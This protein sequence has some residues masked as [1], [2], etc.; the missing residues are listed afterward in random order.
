M[1]DF[2]FLIGEWNVANRRQDKW[3]VGSQT[4]EEF[5]AHVVGR[6]HFD[7]AASFDEMH[8]PTTG[9]RGLSLRLYDPEREEWSIYWASSR[10]GRLEPPVI[11]RFV[12]GVGT[13]EGDDT[14]EGLPIKVRFTWS[15]ITE[16][17]ARWQQ[18][19]SADDG[20]T[21]ELNWV[22]QFTRA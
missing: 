9:T 10:T 18:E 12:D 20:A 1:N 16:T 7:G 5:P 14:Y 11:G 6:V 8:F 19:L 2:D 13:F 3:L 22:M 21:W 15:D 4:Y 17:S